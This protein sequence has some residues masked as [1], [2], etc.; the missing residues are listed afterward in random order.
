[1]FFACNAS[2]GLKKLTK[3][4][5]LLAV[6]SPLGFKTIILSISPNFA[7]YL[8]IISS[9]AVTDKRPDIS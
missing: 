2:S 5:F 3:A 8:Y 1:M 9:E 6:V 4:I 7:K